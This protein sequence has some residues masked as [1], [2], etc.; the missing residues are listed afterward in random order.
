M[1]ISARTWI[2]VVLGVG[3]MGIGLRLLTDLAKPIMLPFFPDVLDSITVIS[4]GLILMYE[5]VRHH[6]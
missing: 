5:G 4:A 6:H 2:Y 1:K 3:V